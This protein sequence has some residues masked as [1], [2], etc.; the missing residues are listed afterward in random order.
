LSVRLPQLETNERGEVVVGPHLKTA[1]TE[2][3]P[4]LARPTRVAPGAEIPGEAFLSPLDAPVYAMP[5]PPGEALPLPDGAVM[6]AVPVPE[7]MVFDGS[8]PEGAAFPSWEDDALAASPLAEPC[9]ARWWN[10]FVVH[11]CQRCGS[12]SFLFVHDVNPYPDAGLGVERVARWRP[13][14]NH[15]SDEYLR[16]YRRL[17]EGPGDGTRFFGAGRLVPLPL[18]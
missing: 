15:A 1:V 18:E 6:E 2:A 17:Y 10:R 14:A 16:E 3:P 8:V 9:F 12:L 13:L 4:Y 5:L 7:G 11:P